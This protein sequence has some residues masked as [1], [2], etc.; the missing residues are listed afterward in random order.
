M[1][2]PVSFERPVDAVVESQLTAEVALGP[3][4][5]LEQLALRLDPHGDGTFL[6]DRVDHRIVLQGGYWYRGEYEVTESSGGSRVEYTIL[7]VA[8][9][10]KLLGRLTGRGEIRRAPRTFQE[11]LAGL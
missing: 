10:A 5:V 2:G 8:P 7:N 3:D 11:L 6:V 9:G 4:R 1:A